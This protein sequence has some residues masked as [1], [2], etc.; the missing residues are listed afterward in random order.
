MQI[1]HRGNKNQAYSMLESLIAIFISSLLLLAILGLIYTFQKT[2]M[3]IDDYVDSNI[4]I[5]NQKANDFT[6]K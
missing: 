1:F 4:E 6:R 2:S 3:S 5:Q